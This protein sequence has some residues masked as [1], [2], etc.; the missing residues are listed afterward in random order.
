MDRWRHV[1]THFERFLGRLEAGPDDYCW[2]LDAAARVLHRVAD[3]DA[4]FGAA[5]RPLHR[6]LVVGAFG[7]RTALKGDR[8]IDLLYVLPHRCEAGRPGDAAARE[9]PW[10]A[11]LADLARRLDGGGQAAEAT[12]DGWLTVTLARPPGAP[13]T[14]PR[15]RVIPGFTRSSSAIHIPLPG[16]VPGNAPWQRI[17]PF[18]QRAHLARVDAMSAGKAR[19]LVRMA[20]AWARFGRVPIRPLALELLAC[21]FVAVWMYRRRS[22]FFYDWMVRDFFFWLAAQ[23]GRS[24]ALPGT[25]E[26]IGTGTGWRQHAEDAHRA[27]ARAADHERDN[28]TRAALASWRRVFGDRFAADDHDELDDDDAA[29]LAATA[30]G[31]ERALVDG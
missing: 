26:A 2:M 21:E 15:V 17:D 3:A 8:C 31:G 11:A 19:A 29:R 24:L 6:P 30:D 7:S 1:G 10:R 25:G 9:A 22:I 4:C 18:T 20:K 5:A 27:A 16:R 28:R 12:A 13:G 14:P 23:H